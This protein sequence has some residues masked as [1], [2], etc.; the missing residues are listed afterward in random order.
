MSFSLNTRCEISSGSC[1]IINP[2][3]TAL[4]C[5][6]ITIRTS[7]YYWPNFYFQLEMKVYEG[8][9][10][11]HEAKFDLCDSKTKP[12]MVKL[13]MSGWAIPD[14]CPIEK[15]FTFCYNPQ[16]MIKLSAVSRKMLK[17]FSAKSS[18]YVKITIT[19]DTGTSCF[20]A[21]NSVVRIE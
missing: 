20:E 1:A 4:V 9:M 13:I 7:S 19:H 2:Y 16:I 21:M 15:S 8:D 17:L 6:F 12:D 3:K 14:Y 10:E 11:L 5:Y 18:E